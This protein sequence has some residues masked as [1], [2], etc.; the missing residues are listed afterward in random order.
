MHLTVKPTSTAFG[1]LVA[2]YKPTSPYGPYE[3]GTSPPQRCTSHKR[4]CRKVLQTFGCDG[5][6]PPLQSLTSPVWLVKWTKRN[7]CCTF[8]NCY[9]TCLHLICVNHYLRV[10]SCL[11]LSIWW[12]GH[13]QSGGGLGA[14]NE[15]CTR[16][17]NMNA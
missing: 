11:R 14:C 2:Y 1:C 17:V 15:I 5:L 10:A 4:Q 6:R 13:A 7:A 9:Y 3:L 8:V 16:S 12:V